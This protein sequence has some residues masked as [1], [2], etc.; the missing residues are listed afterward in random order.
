VRYG[1]KQDRRS[2]QFGLYD[3]RCPPGFEIIDQLEHRLGVPVGFIGWYQ[4][5]GSASS[6]CPTVAIM[7]TCRRGSAP[8][9]TWEPWMLPEDL[10]SGIRRH[11]Q[12]DFFLRAIASGLHDRYV[13]SWARSL[14]AVK[15]R[16]HLRP[17]HEMNGNWYPWGGAVNGNSAPAF[18]EAWRYLR[19]TFREEGAHNVAWVWCP[20]AQ[21]VPDTVENALEQYFPGA[22]QVD[23]LALDGYNWGGTQPWSSWQSFVQVFRPA[24]ERLIRLSP[25]LPVMIAEMG[26]AEEGGNKAAWISEA[27]ERLFSEFTRVQ[28]VVWFNVDKECDWRID[29]SPDS[30]GAFRKEAWRFRGSKKARRC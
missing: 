4:A 28:A 21:S 30:L 26:C 7:E 5:W 11:D 2:I 6:A 17:M 9:I 3:P 29:S 22:A 19:R 1:N 25:T 10:P 12:P 20:Y 16:L 14:A 27:L 8:L 15:K 13:R 18:V 24:Y 23:W